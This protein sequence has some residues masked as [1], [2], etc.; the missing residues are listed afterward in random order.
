MSC[1]RRNGEVVSAWI[2]TSKPRYN[3]TSL[4]LIS[5]LANDLHRSNAMLSSKTREARRSSETRRRGYTHQIRPPLHLPT[6]Q[7]QTRINR[8]PNST[9]IN[10]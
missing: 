7:R 8:Q 10:Q 9:P 2:A 5:Q 4:H 1:S 3:Y 6:S